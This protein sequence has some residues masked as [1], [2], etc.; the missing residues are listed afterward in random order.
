MDDQR[1][2]ELARGLAASSSRRQA[3]KALGGG[4]AGAL[5]SFVGLRGA[6]AKDNDANADADQKKPDCCPKRAPKLCQRTCVDTS[7]DPAHCGKC[8]KSCPPGGRCVKGVCVAPAC[9]E[10]DDCPPPA[11]PCRVAVCSNGQCAT[12]PRCPAGATCDNGAC[13]CPAGSTY[14]QSGNVCVTDCPP[15]APLNPQTCQCDEHHCVSGSPGCANIRCGETEIG[16]RCYCQLTPDGESACIVFPEQ[17]D[18]LVPCGEGRPC[19][20]GSVCILADCCG[21]ATQ[22]CLQLCT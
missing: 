10:S 9:T 6:L 13:I 12:A 8:G 22:L 7:S 21:P 15:F 4:A 2:D 18:E 16:Q 11:N 3:L 14:C 19:D 20:A 5:L 1:F 17:C